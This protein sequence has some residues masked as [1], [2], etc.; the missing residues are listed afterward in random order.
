VVLAETLMAEKVKWYPMRMNL[1]SILK[2]RVSTKST[3]H[4]VTGGFSCT[5]QERCY[6]MEDSLLVMLLVK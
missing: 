3:C 1:Y 2:G 5:Y 6:T 4:Q